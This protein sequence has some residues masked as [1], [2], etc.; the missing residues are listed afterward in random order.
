MFYCSHSVFVVCRDIDRFPCIVLTYQSL[1]LPRVH[2][3]EWWIT[4]SFRDFYCTHLGYLS[5]RIQYFLG[6]TTV[7]TIKTQRL[8]W[9]LASFKIHCKQTLCVTAH[10]ETHAC[11]LYISAFPSPPFRMFFLFAFPKTDAFE[12]LSA[13]PTKPDF[14]ARRF[15]LISPFSSCLV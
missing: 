15:S 8:P 1:T 10:S 11:A 5:L 6:F 2:R 3:V 9:V 12:V 7:L 14:L 13:G 4:V